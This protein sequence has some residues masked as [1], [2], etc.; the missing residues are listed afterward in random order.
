MVWSANCATSGAGVS[1]HTSG[2]Q[3]GS[4]R[5]T[6]TEWVEFTVRPTE[7]GSVTTLVTTWSR[8]GTYTSTANV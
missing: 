6:S 1:V 7:Y 5:S 4:S 2:A 3:R 8:A